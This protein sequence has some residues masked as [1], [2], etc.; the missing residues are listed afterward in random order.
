V[1]RVAIVAL[2]DD[3]LDIEGPLDREVSIPFLPVLD[4]FLFL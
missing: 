2:G 1:E 4:D 3:I